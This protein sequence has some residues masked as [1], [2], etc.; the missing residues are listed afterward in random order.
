M[1]SL[2]EM[3][4]KLAEYRFLEEQREALRRQERE[5]MERQAEQA[6]QL[7][8]QQDRNWREQLRQQEEW[9]RNKS[10]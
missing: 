8:E 7:Q 3:N 6:R 5:F 2:E 9:Y 10:Y 1:D 4:R